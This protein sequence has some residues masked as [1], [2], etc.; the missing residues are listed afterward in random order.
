[1][2]LGLNGTR[3]LASRKQ[4]KTIMAGKV[5][6]T[7][8]DKHDNNLKPFGKEHNVNNKYFADLIVSQLYNPMNLA[9]IICLQFK[10]HSDALVSAFIDDMEMFE[11]LYEFLPKDIIV[12]VLNQIPLDDAI[13]IVKR[14]RTSSFIYNQVDP[15]LYVI[16]FFSDSKEKDSKKKY[17]S[18]DPH[19]K[20]FNNNVIPKDS[21]LEFVL[22]CKNYLSSYEFQNLL[23]MLY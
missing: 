7:K 10:N 2:T 19:C 6:K 13:E 21:I 3:N 8:M 20:E 16:R 14:H 17:I 11:Y 1:M 12:N 9:T 15:I 18:R 23:K 4:L 22:R 5:N